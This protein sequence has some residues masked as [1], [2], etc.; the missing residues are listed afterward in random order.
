MSHTAGT[1]PRQSLGLQQGVKAV[2]SQANPGSAVPLYP[3]AMPWESW[4]QY[5]PK[6][7]PWVTAKRK[8]AFILRQSP[9]SAVAH[10]CAV[11]I[12]VSVLTQGRAL[13]YSNE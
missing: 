8:K 3:M 12:I 5:F 10:G 7:E 9:S 11:G 13:G 4:C 1:F 6:A 2:F